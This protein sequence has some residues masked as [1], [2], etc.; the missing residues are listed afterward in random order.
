MSRGTGG[1]IV[2]G[3]L[4][5]L[6]V[7][8]GL[9]RVRQAV[10]MPI[11][12]TAPLPEIVRPYQMPT[13]RPGAEA[14]DAKVRAA[15]DILNKRVAELQKTLSAREAEL[16]ALKQNKP[17]VAVSPR[18]P[19]R[20]DFQ[21]RME[22]MKKEH[23]EQYAEMEKR[24]EEFQ[25]RMEQEKQS[26]ADFLSSLN[27]QAMSEA[28]KLNHEKLLET[29]AKLEALRTQREQGK[30][31]T[32]ADAEQVSRE[33]LRQ[34]MDELRTLYDQERSYLFEQAATAAGYQ[35]DDVTKF[36]DYL[37]TAIQSTT[38]PWHGGPGRGGPPP[39]M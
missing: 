35:G 27:T 9:E 12:E 18:R 38:M 1:L 10:L 17:A 4:A 37:Q 22:Q 11:P 16:V 34:T 21:K 24:R 33:T 36:V 23:P 15:L 20:E 14:D 3:A 39:G 2:V 25:Q 26:Q 5:C 19:S 6:V 29:I 32:G 7:G 30:T 31:E 13:S 28:Q 8:A